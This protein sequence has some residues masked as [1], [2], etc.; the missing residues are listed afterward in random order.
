MSVD[1]CICL[2]ITVTTPYFSYQWMNK[3]RPLVIAKARTFVEGKAPTGA[4]HPDTVGCMHRGRFRQFLQNLG[5]PQISN[6][7]A[8]TAF[9]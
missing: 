9:F 6:K 4:I 2:R 8:R 1:H 3:V 7:Q 5:F